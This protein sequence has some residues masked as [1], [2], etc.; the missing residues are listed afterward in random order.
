[1]NTELPPSTLWTSLNIAAPYNCK[2]M[3]HTYCQSDN[4]LA[5]VAIDRRTV[6]GDHYIICYR[7]GVQFRNVVA[8]S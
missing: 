5:C 1:M 2:L 7:L 4:L 8:S 6:S 3:A